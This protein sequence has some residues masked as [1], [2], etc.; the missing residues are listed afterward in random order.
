[1][2]EYHAT[3]RATH[4]YASRWWEWPFDYVPVAYYYQDL[5]ADRNDPHACC[6]EE[7]TSMPSPVILWFG[8]FAVPFAGV[9]AW[10]E[11]NAGYAVIVLTYLLQWMPWSLSP[12]LA[13]E[14][15]FYVNVPLICACE[16]VV[17]ARFW[18]WGRAHADRGN[19]WMAAIA[20]GGFV[21]AAGYAFVFFY[22]VLSATPIT[23]DAWHARMWLPTWVIGPG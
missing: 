11:R 21:L 16:A 22:P 7:V 12:R 14:Y 13:W 2:F 18:Q 1:M 3:L 8:V 20:T 10:R 23:W 19:A 5:R 6:I 17:F 9:L 15:H 4:P